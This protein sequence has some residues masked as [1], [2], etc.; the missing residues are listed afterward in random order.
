[1]RKSKVLLWLGLFLVALWVGTHW[2]EF[3]SFVNRG[4]GIMPTIRERI[5]R[6]ESYTRGG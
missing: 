6:G 3:I 1:M 5:D 4:W 2:D